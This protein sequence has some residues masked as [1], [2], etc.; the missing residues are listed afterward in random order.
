MLSR[1]GDRLFFTRTADPGF[2]ASLLNDVGQVTSNKQDA[3]Y[4]DLLVSIYSEIAGKAV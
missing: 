3:R 1:N 4:Q 2:E